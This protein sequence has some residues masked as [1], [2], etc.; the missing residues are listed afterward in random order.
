MMPDKKQ[1]RKFRLRDVVFFNK[2][3]V[4]HLWQLIWKA[5]DEEIMESEGP[6]LRLV[7]QKNGHKKSCIHHEKMGNNI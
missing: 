7:N 6:T 1:T 4:L 2:Y 5:T 3:K